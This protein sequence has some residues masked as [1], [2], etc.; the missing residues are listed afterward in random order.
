MQKILNNVSNYEVFE[1]NFEALRLALNAQGEQYSAGWFHGIAGSAFRVGGICP[2]APTCTFAMSPQQLIK[3]LGYEYTECPY[4]DADKEGA[5]AKAVT[6]VRASIDN[7]VPAMVWHAF[8]MC[9]WDVVAGYDAAENVFFGRSSGPGNAGDYAKNPWNNTLSTFA[10]NGIM[11]ITIQKSSGTFDK[12][13]AEIAAIR[14]AIRHANNTE[15]TDKLGGSEWV[16]LQGKAAYKR[17]ANDFSNPDHKRG[18]G[19]A[20]C[21][22]IYASSHGMAAPFLREIAPNYP[23]AADLLSQ[24]AECFNKEAAALRNLLP[25]LGWNSPEADSPRNERAVPFLRDAAGYYS[26]AIDLLSTAV[27]KM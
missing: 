20:Y 12:R 15:N 26:S 25:L 24:A 17:W 1:A 5:L 10:S 2:C 6:A 22:G 8:S 19:D 13:N 21:I 16:F 18:L 11:A 14:E 9:E 23:A 7:G 27:E 3:L 4:D